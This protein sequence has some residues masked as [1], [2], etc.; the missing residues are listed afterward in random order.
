MARDGESGGA[1]GGA[2]AGRERHRLAEAAGGEDG[3]ED[4]AGAG[5]IDGRDRLGEDGD[6]AVGIEGKRAARAERHHDE[7]GAGGTQSLRGR[8]RIVAATE[9]SGLALV[10]DEAIGEWHEAGDVR[11]G[12][13]GVE[14]CRSAGGPRR[15]ERRASRGEGQIALHDEE[16]AG[17]EQFHALAG[18]AL[19]DALGGRD[20]RGDGILAAR[21]D[22]DQRSIRRD[23][24]GDEVGGIEPLAGEFACHPFARGVAADRRDEADI[25]AGA[26]H[27][28][29]LVGPLA[30][31]I[32]P[33]WP[34]D[35]G[36]AGM[37]EDRGRHGLVDHRRPE[38]ENPHRHSSPALLSRPAT[39]VAMIA[40]MGCQLLEAG[41]QIR[42]TNTYQETLPWKRDALAE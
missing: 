35:H 25:E 27:H 18:E 1:A 38:D 16:I 21:P 8:K 9:K 2:K 11:P 4:I 37:R 33:G 20:D 26:A 42:I 15:L 36:G 29:R 17:A 28:E 39:S 6:G 19:V 34:G 41:L 5:G 7:A 23:L 12:R 24:G 30:A 3:G 13:R 22:K 14:Q 31:E 10:D 32:A 40:A